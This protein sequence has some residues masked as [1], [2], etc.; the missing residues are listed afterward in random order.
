[1]AGCAAIA[2]RSPTAGSASRTVAPRL[3]NS[4]TDIADADRGA[5]GAA[6]RED[7]KALADDRHRAVAH[8]GGAE[9]FG[10]ERRRFLELER[11]FLRG[12]EAVAATEDEQVGGIAIR[13]DRGRPVERKGVVEAGRQRI[14]RVGQRRI[15]RP[16]G[17][18]RGNRCERADIGFGRGNRAFDP[19]RQR[20]HDVGEVGQRG[21]GCVDERD[22]KGAGRA[23][24]LDRGQQVGA[25]ARLRNRQA[26]P[27]TD[28]RGGV[29]ERGDRQRGG[30][31]RRS[32]HRFDQI[33]GVGC[34]M[35]R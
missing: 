12:A 13:G 8:F 19:G 30:R 6:E 26:Q 16:G 5:V 28:E 20:D 1:M 21:I 32:C 34:G 25:L 9:T 2:G 22:D 27:V 10:V 7:V 33:F 29:I 17:D 23:L 14:K 35:I 31:G 3:R 24:L 18:K 15:F 4:A 11:G